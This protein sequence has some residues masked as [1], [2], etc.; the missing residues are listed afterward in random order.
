MARSGIAFR[1][2]LISVTLLYVSIKAWEEV[3][4]ADLGA[5][6]HVLAPLTCTNL[7]LITVRHDGYNY[8]HPT[9]AAQGYDCI[10]A[11]YLFLHLQS[12]LFQTEKKTFRH[13]MC[14]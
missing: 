10:A 6:E 12:E 1:G 5:N 13:K 9:Q 3:L 14:M 2:K 11:S 7:F 4:L 8:E